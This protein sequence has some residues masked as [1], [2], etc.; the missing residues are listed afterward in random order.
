MRKQIITIFLSALVTIAILSFAHSRDLLASS[1]NSA[2]NA[3][4]YI[5]HQGFLADSNGDPISDGSYAMRFGVYTAVSGGSPIWQETQNNVPVSQGYFAVMLG[6]GSCTTGCPLGPDTFDAPSRYLQTSVDTGS[7]FVN[8]PRQLL[9]SVPYAFQ[10]ASVPWDGVTN[11]PDMSDTLADLSC[12]NGQIAKWNGSAWICAEDLTG[13]SYENVIVVAKSGGDFTSVAA[14]L[15]SITDASESNRYLVRVAPGIY[16]ESS[17]IEV[18]GYVHLRGDGANITVVKSSRS[19]ADAGPAAS[20]VHLHHAGRIS[21]IHVINEGSSNTYSIGIFILDADK[22]ITGIVARRQTVV[23]NVISEA[24]GSGGTRHYGLYNHN[25]DP[26]IQDSIFRASGASGVGSFN[27][28]VGNY[29]TSNVLITN[30]ILRSEAGAAFGYG[31]V[32]N[33][34]NPHIRYSDINGVTNAIRQEASGFTD[35]Q[36]SRLSASNAAILHAEAGQIQAATSKLIGLTHSSGNVVCAYMI[37]S[38]G[39]EATCP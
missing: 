38:T 10:A 32:S 24:N 9:G 18:P 26:L 34:S 20:T 15:N 31:M 30:S 1:N 21:D 12:S 7:G 6:S 4:A 5:S 13:G 39:G 35:V 8:F 19:A 27:A 2:N 29:S 33:A 17:L 16:D 14:A 37:T 3:P 36:S 28:A 22:G 23:S 25:S 11:P